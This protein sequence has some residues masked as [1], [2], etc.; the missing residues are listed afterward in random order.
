MDSYLFICVII[1]LIMLMDDL[2][3]LMEMLCFELY[4]RVF[5]YQLYNDKLTHKTA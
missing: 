3:H 5:L 4:Y 2:H 1:Q